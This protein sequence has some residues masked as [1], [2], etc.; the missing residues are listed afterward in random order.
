MAIQPNID[1]YSI[2]KYRHNLG[3][4][5]QHSDV[6]THVFIKI[7]LKIDEKAF[8]NLSHTCRAFSIL[9]AKHA[10]PIAKNHY[11]FIRACVTGCYFTIKAWMEAKE[12]L[13]FSFRNN[14][15]LSIVC[16]AEGKHNGFSESD[17]NRILET[18]LEH[19]KKD[20]AITPACNNNYC[21]RAACENGN[22]LIVRTLLTDGRSDPTVD[23]PKVLRDA[24][25]FACQNGHYEVVDAL[26]ENSEVVVPPE[27]EEFFKKHPEKNVELKELSKRCSFDPL[28]NYKWALS[29]ACKKNHSKIVARLLRHPKVDPS[30][31]ASAS[32]YNASR[33]GS[34]EVAQ[35]LLEDG[36]ADPSSDANLALRYAFANGD[37]EMR[38]LLLRS[39]R[40]LVTCL[41]YCTWVRD[42][43][44]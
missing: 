32:I 16:A 9:V 30:V 43:P 17:Y 36:R 1:N 27:E 38:N 13:N 23:D 34:L 44:Y 37:K 11:F 33:Y 24:L 10:D 2:N 4:F 22:A 6:L 19:S 40:V 20:P 21:I 5:S 25:F 35:L 31:S 39:K 3:C 15:P 29:V 18:I 14:S 8:E 42:V 41:D 26:L 28:K 12:N 7:A